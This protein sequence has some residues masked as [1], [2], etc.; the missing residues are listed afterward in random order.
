MVRANGN[1]VE[2]YAYEVYGKPTIK[3]GAGDDGTW[4][5][6]DDITSTSSARG[7][8]YFFTAR[9][10]VPDI[11]LQFN[12]A[13]WYSPGAG[14][15]L[16]RDPV[17]YAGGINVYAYVS[18]NPVSYA[19]LFGLRKIVLTI[20]LHNCPWEKWVQDRV[21]HNL[22]NILDT[23]FDDLKCDTVEIEV[24]RKTR[25]LQDEALGLFPRE[26]KYG[27]P[28]NW[29]HEVT[30]RRRSRHRFWLAYTNGPRTSVNVEAI[31]EQ[32]FRRRDVDRTAQRRAY[33]NIL[34][35]EILYIG[36]WGRSDQSGSDVPE[37]Y[38]RTAPTSHLV[39]IPK[40]MCDALKEKLKVR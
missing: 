18:A 2:A 34:A 20:V 11:S 1:I 6:A 19:D 15:W 24:L 27:P 33:A 35:H 23:C 16:S 14:R 36:I 12:R 9:R 17:G 5:T 30:F 31:E 37:I 25:R 21:I 39:T 3:T 26:S 4:F 29:T 22:K 40:E 38:T 8:P 13:R 7:N 10:W 28:H 32:V